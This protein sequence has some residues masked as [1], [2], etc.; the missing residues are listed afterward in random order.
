MNKQ[1][2]WFS[3]F[4]MKHLPIPSFTGCNTGL[5]SITTLNFN[6]SCAAKNKN[7]RIF[8]KMNRLHSFF[9]LLQRC[10]VL[11]LRYQKAWPL[12]KWDFE[13]AV[14]RTHFLFHLTLVLLTFLSAI[15]IE[16][17]GSTCCRCYFQ[18][19]VKNYKHARTLYRTIIEPLV[20]ARGLKSA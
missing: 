1:I 12:A 4:W 11:E 10:T 20:E 16:T 18:L 8:T 13:A 2:T 19:F 6:D 9:S 15:V 5:F 7:K 3:I 14:Y 17:R